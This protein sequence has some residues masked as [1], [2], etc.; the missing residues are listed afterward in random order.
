MTFAAY[1]TGQRDSGD[2]RVTFYI[3]HELC[4]FN[5]GYNCLD[6][7]LEGGKIVE[8]K[9][10]LDKA[11]TN[12]DIVYCIAIP[13]FEGGLSEKSNSEMVF[14]S[15][16]SDS[17]P[18]ESNTTSDENVNGIN[19]RPQFAISDKIYFL[20]NRDKISL[21]SSTN[22][23]DVE[24]TLQ[25]NNPE[26]ISAHGDHISVLINNGGEYVAKLYDNNLKEIKSAD[27]SALQIMP[28]GIVDFDNDRIVYTA[29]ADKK[30]ALYSCDWNLQNKRKL[31]ELPCEEYPLASYFD[32]ISLSKNFVAF[33]AYGNEG[34]IK[35]GFYG[36]CDFNGNYEIRRKDGI[37]APQTND[38]TAMWQDKHTNINSGKM[39]SGKIEI[40]KDG[41]FSTLITEE[42]TESHR[43]FLLNS[44]EVITATE[45]GSWDLRKY[46]DNRVVRKI[47]IRE[48]TYIASVV[49]FNGKIYGYVS[50]YLPSLEKS[51]SNCLVW[52]SD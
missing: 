34:D 16:Q 40:Y 52:E 1:T 8:T 42:I 48:E 28:Q 4:T 38:T 35:A 21:I 43:A 17:K 32:G 6:L 10:V 12:G 36:I 18:N 49:E 30:T 37:A 51:E 15:D 29:I 46:S 11:L 45:S 3:N 19:F 7:T 44:G 25:L 20:D 14:D 47:G 50:E 2:Y 41:S 31:M 23:S 27:L 24:K 26:N 5:S 13:L 39:P 33:T 22:G 9:V